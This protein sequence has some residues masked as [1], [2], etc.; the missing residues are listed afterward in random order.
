MR[1]NLK[2]L[3]VYADMYQFLLYA[4]VSRDWVTFAS[5]Q[6]LVCSMLLI[7]NF[8]RDHT[9]PVNI[10]N[11]HWEGSDSYNGIMT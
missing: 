9:T 5:E 7:N 10:F 6:I 2:Q 8:E 1:K 3:I 11:G 4:A